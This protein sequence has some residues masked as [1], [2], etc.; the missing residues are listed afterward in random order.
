MDWGTG[1]PQQDAPQGASQSG[2]RQTRP[3]ANPHTTTYQDAEAPGA[4]PEDGPDW[5]VGRGSAPPE[6]TPGERARSPWPVAVR[7]QRLMGIAF[8]LLG[9][10]LATWSAMNLGD[11]AEAGRLWIPPWLVVV[12]AG[13]G[14]VS[15]AGYLAWAGGTAVRGEGERWEPT[16]LDAAAGL[17]VGTVDAVDTGRLLTGSRDDAPRSLPAGGSASARGAGA[18]GGPARVP[19]ESG[20]TPL[21][22]SST[23]DQSSYAPAGVAG[24]VGGFMLASAVVCAILALPLGPAW[25]LGTAFLAV[26]GITAVRLAGDWLGHV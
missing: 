23:L 7:K 11:N 22:G 3:G 17:T 9:L 10:F 26:G 1:T 14:L 15:A 20:P 4:V 24:A 19:L 8:A 21:M 18:G 13:A 6:P 2:P 16:V 25:L 5:G 12:L